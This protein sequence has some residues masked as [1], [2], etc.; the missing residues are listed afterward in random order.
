MMTDEEEVIG[1]LLDPAEDSL[2]GDDPAENL[3]EYFGWKCGYVQQRVPG[4]LELDYGPLVL[5]DLP[6]QS[7]YGFD[8]DLVT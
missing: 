4:A 2:G 7:P 3:P 6:L 8:V 5:F 1:S